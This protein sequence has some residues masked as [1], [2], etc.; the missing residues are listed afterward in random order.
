MRLYEFG[1]MLKFHLVVAAESEN[2]A[3]ETI[4]TFERTWSTQ[5]DLIE[6][7]DVDLVDVRVPESDD[8]DDEAHIIA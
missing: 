7:S 1:A 2:D 4:K 8:L 5:G 3:R 6:V